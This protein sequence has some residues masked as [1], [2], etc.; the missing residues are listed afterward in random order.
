[1]SDI[2]ETPPAYPMPRAKRED[3]CPQADTLRQMGKDIKAIL[4]YIN[5]NGTPEKGF[6]LR[7]ARL[8]D[9]QK[10]LWA[11]LIV[12]IAALCGLA[13]ETLKGDRKHSEAETPPAH[14]RLA[15]DAR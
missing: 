3:D 14:T 10:L 9:K 15:G 8:E 5:G 13:W 1:M 4:H 12:A 6:I 7:M 2:Q 11:A